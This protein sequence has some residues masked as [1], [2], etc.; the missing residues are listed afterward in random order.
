LV[1]T[2]HSGNQI[3]DAADKLLGGIYFQLWYFLC[4]KQGLSGVQTEA[5]YSCIDFAAS[6]INYTCVDGLCCCCAVWKEYM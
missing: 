5:G 1:A 2:H 3:R 4:I 6:I